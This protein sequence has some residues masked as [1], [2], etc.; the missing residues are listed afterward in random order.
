[1]QK[2]E[3]QMKR[4]MREHQDIVQNMKQREVELQK[5]VMEMQGAQ[6]QQHSVEKA[7]AKEKSNQLQRELDTAKQEKEEVRQEIEKFH[8]KLLQAHKYAD[9]MKKERDSAQ[10]AMTHIQVTTQ[11]QINDLQGKVKDLQKVN[12]QLQ[13]SY[14]QLSSQNGYDSGIDESRHSPKATNPSLAS[15][16]VTPTGK[17][18]SVSM[19]P[20]NAAATPHRSGHG[21]YAQQ[22]DRI[23]PLRITITPMRQP[24]NF[25]RDHRLRQSMPDKKF[26]YRPPE[27]RPQPVPEGK[28]SQASSRRSSIRDTPVSSAAQTPSQSEQTTPTGSQEALVRGRHRGSDTV[29]CSTPTS[30]CE[31]PSFDLNESL[32]SISSSTNGYSKEDK[33]SRILRTLKI[34]S[35]ETITTK[36]KMFTK[37]EKARVFIDKILELQDYND[38]LSQENTELKKKLNS[39]RFS[40]DRVDRLEKK[41][42]ELEAENQKLRKML[43]IYNNYGNP[44]DSR[45]YHYYSNV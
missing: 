21:K 41:I 22:F 8:K 23:N 2:Q 32:S 40:E 35:T 15:V 25:S 29:D 20:D 42:L 34:T 26:M 18:H 36:L 9:S 44:N 37:S 33:I 4:L 5:Q 17:P 10:Q 28:M 38:R 30:H 7:A 16:P 1:M 11:A 27:R 3:E 6:Q 13:E 12:D 43:D 45:T 14:S 31:T 39:L 24:A 19:H